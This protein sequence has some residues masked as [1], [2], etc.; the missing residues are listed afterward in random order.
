[1]TPK[2]SRHRTSRHEDF[3]ESSLSPKLAQMMVHV[4]VGVSHPLGP[5]HLTQ[6]CVRKELALRTTEAIKKNAEILQIGRELGR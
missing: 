6:C 2:E 4:E 1:M 5:R 3:G